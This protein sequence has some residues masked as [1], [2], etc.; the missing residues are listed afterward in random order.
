MESYPKNNMTLSS[1]SCACGTNCSCTTNCQCGSSDE[2]ETDL[3]DFAYKTRS[4]ELLDMIEKERLERIKLGVQPLVYAKLFRCQTEMMHKNI[5][6]SVMNNARA[7]MLYMKESS[8][9]VASSAS[10]KMMTIRDK[11]V[12]M[13]SNLISAAIQKETELEIRATPYIQDIDAKAQ[14][15]SMDINT[16]VKELK[17]DFNDTIMEFNQVQKDY[18]TF[19]DEKTH[20][21]SV[22]L[23]ESVK[24]VDEKSTEFS[25]ATN[26]VVED[27]KDNFVGPNISSAAAEEKEKI[28]RMGEKIDPVVEGRKHRVE[29]ELLSKMAH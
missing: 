15:I 16:S 28:R 21:L 2:I 4:S 8:M 7:Q 1:G 18:T 19:V 11:I 3:Y 29:S 9:E 13:A 25:V 22:G 5:P 10:E 6:T 12:T 20:E 23:T 14:K 24:M 17:K 27:I 26:Q